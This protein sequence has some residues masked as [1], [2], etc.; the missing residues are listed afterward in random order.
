MI[1]Q[2]LYRTDDISTIDFRQYTEEL[3]QK[4]DAIQI[5]KVTF[6]LDIQFDKTYTFDIDTS[7]SLGLILNELITNSYK[8]ALLDK[9]S[10]KIGIR[11]Q[12]D[13]SGYFKML[14]SDNGKA[15]KEPFAQ[16]V[17]KG[18]G[19]R[20]ASRLSR[21]LQGRFEYSFKEYNLFTVTFANQALREQIADD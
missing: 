1:H 4:L 8:H 19:L 13:N 5:E 12:D 9:R 6:D 18:F 11:M 21:Q 15:I 16:V 7:I 10:L 2:F 20:L 3:A 17:K 14:Y